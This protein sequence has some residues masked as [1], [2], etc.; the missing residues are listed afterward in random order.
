MAPG[1]RAVTQEDPVSP[2]WAIRLRKPG[3]AVDAGEPVL[4]LHVDDT[5][6]LDGAL[7]A[8]DGAIEVGPEPP[9]PA[10]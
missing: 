8:L 2:T 1:C 9:D 6:R 4:V 10:R 7:A 3:D 5:A